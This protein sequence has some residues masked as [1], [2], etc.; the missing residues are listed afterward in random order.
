[1]TVE[2]PRGEHRPESDEERKID[3]ERLYN[4]SELIAEASALIS[5]L[6]TNRVPDASSQTYNYLVA[7][8]G[9][10]SL[11]KIVLDRTITRELYEIY[12]TLD[13][14]QG[15]PSDLRLLI[16]DSDSTLHISRSG[17]GENKEEPDWFIDKQ[18]KTTPT[19]KISKK[20]I[21][22]LIKSLIRPNMDGDYS[23]FDD[24]NFLDS[25]LFED[26]TDTLESTATSVLSIGTYQLNN[27]ANQ[28][29]YLLEQK[30]PVTFSLTY[31]AAKPGRLII[32]RI[33]C[34]HGIDVTFFAR[35][36][37]EQ[38]KLIPDLK[39]IIHLREIL[40]QELAASEPIYVSL[41]HNEEVPDENN[42][43]LW[44]VPL[45][46]KTKK[47][48]PPLFSDQYPEPGSNLD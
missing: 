5:S 31:E 28:L 42:N 38:T 43:A 7:E 47:I 13:S 29:D 17:T 33:D 16:V 4:L 24:T 14:E 39:D 30:Q 2:V 36:N 44:N 11:P 26:L 21:N 27:G 22:W 20:E 10:I 18:G 45:G 9:S 19:P 41:G 8:T 46:T 12:L 25:N 1:M 15:E 34:Q 35:E 23:Q 6:M 32:A 3:I 48:M 40:Q 37:G